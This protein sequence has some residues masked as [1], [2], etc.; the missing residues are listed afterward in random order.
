M[1]I[2]AKI[3]SDAIN[4]KI[5]GDE[6]AIITG[7]SNIENTTD[8]T[9][10]FISAKKYSKYLKTAKSSVIIVSEEFFP[11]ENDDITKDSNIINNDKISKDITYILVPDAHQAFIELMR[12]YAKMSKPKV[13]Y[14]ISEKSTISSSAIVDK[15]T[16]IGDFTVIG[17]NTKI[18]TNVQIHPQVFIGNNVEIESNTIIYP[19]VKIYDNTK[20]GKNC[21]IHSNAVIGADGF[22]FTQENNVNIK[23]PQL[24]NV[25]IKDDVEVGA[26]CTIDKAT[27]GST[28]IANGVKLD[29]LIHIAHNCYIGENT[30]IASQTGIAGSTKIG[31]NCMIG[32]QVGM[33]DHITIGDNVKIVAKS[34]LMRNV[35]DNSILMG[36]PAFNHMDFLK[37]YSIFKNLPNQK[38]EK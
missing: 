26:N 20:I 17:N 16:Y 37:S 7:F 33:I 22:G 8:N 3:I 10:S 36:A 23:V 25:V 13:E 19:G 32:G 27:M 9:I 11:Q 34:G 5:I 2:T 29:N 12:V 31:K 30:V 1:T 35:K 6:N 28:T 4:G 24:G 15:E 38:N 14:K 18:G 21:I